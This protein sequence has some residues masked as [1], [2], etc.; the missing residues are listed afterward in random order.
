MTYLYTAVAFAIVCYGLFRYAMK[1]TID[2]SP[3]GSMILGMSGIFGL[4]SVFML[5][6]AAAKLF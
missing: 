3:V 4:L 2:A 1:C 6:A 5:G